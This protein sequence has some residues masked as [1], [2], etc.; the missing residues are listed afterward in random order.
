MQSYSYIMTLVCDFMQP[1]GCNT[2]KISFIDWLEAQSFLFNV[3]LLWIY[4]YRK[5]LI[6]TK[7]RRILQWENL[8]IGGLGVKIFGP[9]TKLPRN[10]FLYQI[11]SNKSFGIY[12]S[13]GVLTPYGAEKKARENA[14]WKVESSITLRR[15]R[16]AVIRQRDFG[17]SGTFPGIFW[18]FRSTLDETV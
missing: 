15:Y 10:T 5:W 14:H 3:Q 9:I 2:N 4:D 18:R 6:F 17:S 1:H 8:N 13:S 11:W 7:N 16:A 12:A